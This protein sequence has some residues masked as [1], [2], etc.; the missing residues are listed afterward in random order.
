MFKIK[1]KESYNKDI[2]I[3]DKKL[4]F[5]QKFKNNIQNIKNKSEFKVQDN[6][7]DT[8]E[9]AINKVERFNENI[10]DNSRIIRK[11]GK[12]SIKI[13]KNNIIKSK[14]KISK[15]KPKILKN[16]INR[17]LKR[18]KTNKEKKKI[19]RQSIKAS[20]RAIEIA[21]ESS[22]KTYK[23]IKLLI[24]GTITGIK[25]LIAGTKALI[26]AL[27][28]C[29]WIAVLIIVII[30]FIG[31]LCSS[32]YG[33][34]F[35]NEQAVNNEITISSIVKALNTELA[36]RI[37]DIQNGNEYDDYSIESNRA[38]WEDVLSIYAIKTSFDNND[39]ITLDEDKRLLIKQIFWDMNIIESE[40]LIKNEEDLE[41]DTIIQK[42]VLNIKIKSKQIDEIAKQYNFTEE[43]INNIKELQNEEYG[44]LWSSAIYGTP[45]GSPNI[46]QVAL[47]QVGNV[48]GETYWSWYGFT[49]RVEWC[50]VF[51]SWVANELGYIES[52]TIPKFAGVQN[53]IDW[54]KAMGEWQD[55]TYVPKPGDIIFFDWENDGKA[56]HVGI[57]EKVENNKVYTIEGNSTNDTCKQKEYSLNSKVIYGYGTPAY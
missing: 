34:F 56:N 19:A 54:F 14:D 30:C 42:R 38:S 51:V 6:E 37:S 36:T 5:H 53:G 24:K 43:Q 20:K 29:G 44:L 46:V 48:G 13:T 45:I 18:S 27:A 55:N 16:K 40:I 25:T 52:K 47:E 8:N 9:Y 39:V 50:A 1:T 26:Y 2:K 32:F 22:T 31:L 4:I 7:N 28:S 17:N 10:Y 49:K 23:G 12:N 35:S 15:I 21:K 41:N 11:K 33:V 57:V 3:L